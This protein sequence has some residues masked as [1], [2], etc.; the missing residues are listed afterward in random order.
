[1]HQVLPPLSNQPPGDGVARKATEATSD[2]VPGSVTEM[3]TNGS[4]RAMPGSHRCFCS[5]VP[6]S[7]KER[8]MIS[9]RVI[10]LPAAPSDARE[11]SS[12]T[13][14]IPRLSSFSSGLRPPYRSGTER[15]KQPSSR[16]PSMI[17]SGTR[18]SSRCICSASGTT[19]SSA[20]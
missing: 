11:S 15:P 5:S 20:N 16:T 10:R 7:S 17:E 14:T 1:M 4:P 12:V 8:A 9:G 2:P 19:C 13:T 6:P 18:R 3:A